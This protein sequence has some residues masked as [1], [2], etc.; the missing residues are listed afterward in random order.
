VDP[1]PTRLAAL[2]TELATAGLDALLITSAANIRY[3]TGFSGSSALA[4]VSQA[5]VVLIT[6]FRYRVQARAEAG[7]AVIVEI[8]GTSLWSRLWTVLPRLAGVSQVG[9]ESPH[10]THADYQRLMDAGARWPWRPTTGIVEGLRQQKDASEVAC[11]RAAVSIAESALEFTVPEIRAG[12]TELAVGA[13]LER[14]LRELGSEAHPFETIV[15][16]GERSA[17]PHARCTSRELRNGDLLVIDFGATSGGYCSDITRTFV[18]GP[19]SDGQREAHSVVLEANASAS[20]GVRAGMRGKDADSLARD[21]I[22]RRGLG[23]EFGHSLGHGIGLEVHEAP[24]LSKTADAPLPANSVV[25]IEPGI[26]RDGWGGIR[27][28]DDVLLAPEGPVVLTSFP[29]ALLQLG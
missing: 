22:Q 27:I 7:S 18:V 6:D 3:T 1:R 20:G 9:F 23:G 10:L 29:R 28:E 12:M 26:Y 15:A 14:T 4:V 11:I 25:T 21:Y 16:S 8:E 19:A 17:L 13:R 5:E 2:R 24:R